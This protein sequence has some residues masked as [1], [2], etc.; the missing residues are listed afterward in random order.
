MRHRVIIERDVFVGEVNRPGAYEFSNQCGFSAMS[1]ARQNDQPA[2][3]CNG[4]GV[5]KDS[6]GRMFGNQMPQ[7]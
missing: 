7:M 3:P 1:A 6:V 4:S 2:M 5:N